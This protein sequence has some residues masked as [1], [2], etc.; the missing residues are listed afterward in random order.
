MFLCKNMVISPTSS[1]VSE[2]V[3]DGRLTGPSQEWLKE[4][5]LLAERRLKDGR[6]SCQKNG[7]RP[8]V[9]I[10]AVEYRD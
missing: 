10:L 3:R 4:K 5:G 2:A 6:T 9:G 8:Y 1:M 7:R